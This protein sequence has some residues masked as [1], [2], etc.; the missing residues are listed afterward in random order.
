MGPFL[1]SLSYFFK[2]QFFI[3]VAFQH[4]KQHCA[5]PRF[6]HNWLHLSAATVLA[7]N[8][9]HMVLY[10]VCDPSFRR[11]HW[12]NMV[13]GKRS[14]D[15][16]KYMYIFLNFRHNFSGDRKVNGLLA[17]VVLQSSLVI[18]QIASHQ[19]VTSSENLV[20]IAQFLIALAC[21]RALY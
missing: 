20:A 3:L 5:W 10:C 15:V 14:F 11:A 18:R 17:K 9:K 4:Y 16:S 19:L 7:S 2:T 12:N 8:E 6:L 13:C 21:I 1:F